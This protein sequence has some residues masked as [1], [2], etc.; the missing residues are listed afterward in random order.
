MTIT[1]TAAENAG[2]IRASVAFEPAELIVDDGTPFA[3][4][5]VVMLAALNQLAQQHLESKFGGV[6]QLEE[7]GTS[8]SVPG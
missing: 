7:Q 3:R 6:A 1:V 2:P 5:V 8:E 4:A